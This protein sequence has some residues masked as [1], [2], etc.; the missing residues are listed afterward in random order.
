MAAT[1]CWNSGL[2]G[3][4]AAA[5][6]PPRIASGESGAGP[7]GAAGPLPADSAPPHA[8]ESA[9][10]SSAAVPSPAAL[11]PAALPTPALSFRISLRVSLDHGQRGLYAPLRALDLVVVELRAVAIGHVE[12]VRHPL[13]LGVD[14][15]EVDR[16]LL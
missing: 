7:A 16:D 1:P 13:A 8:K 12:Y 11:P 5:S 3:V 9:T 4:A 2:S 6:S 14:L 15:G 10:A